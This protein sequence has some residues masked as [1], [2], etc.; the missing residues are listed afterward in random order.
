MAWVDGPRKGGS[1]SMRT[2][3]ATRVGMEKVVSLR[4]CRMEERRVR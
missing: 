2:V 1:L 3:K 4:F